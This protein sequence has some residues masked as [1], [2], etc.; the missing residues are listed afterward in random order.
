MA[1]QSMT[2]DPNAAAYTDDQIVGKVNA[3]ATQITRAG[4][5]A[6][7]ARPLVDG[8]VTATKLAAAAA[9]DNLDAIADTVRGYVQ[10][11]PAAGQFPIISI[12]RQ[13]DGKMKVDF[14]DVPA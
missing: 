7:A 13:A 9:R 12:E 6:A 10:T 4:A 5:V 14:D 8:E 2:L 3:A 11:N 1:I